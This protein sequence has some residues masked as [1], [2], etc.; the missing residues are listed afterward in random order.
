MER[1]SPT[2]TYLSNAEVG[3]LDALYHDYQAN[4][5]SVDET[6][7]RFFEGFEFARSKY[8]QNGKTATAVAAAAGV[9]EE[10]LGR[11]H[12]VQELINAYR[13]RGHLFAKINPILP[14]KKY[15]PPISLEL[16]GLSESDL[17][18]EFHAGNLLGIGTAK[19]RDIVAFLE[20]TYC[21]TIGAEYRYIRI[22][23]M[24]EWL[25]HKMEAKRNLPTFAPAEKQHILEML[26]K[27]TFFENFIHRKFPGQKRFS[28]EGGESIIPALDSLIMQG[29]E[30][31]VKEFVIGMAHRGRLNILTN[32]L[33]KEPDN[34]FGEFKDKGVSDSIFDGDVKYH[35]GYSSDPV[36]A[37]GKTVHLSLAPNP[38][39]LEAVAPVVAGVTRAKMEM[40][41]GNDSDAICPIIIHGDASVAGQGIVYELIQMSRL[42][43]YQTGGTVHFVINNQIGFTTPEDD[44]R[45]STYCTDVAK[46]TASPVFHVNG[47]D[48]EAVAYVSRLAMEFRQVFKRDVFVDIICYRKYGHN[49]GD[50]PRF[51]QPVMYA[52]IAKHPS[53]YEIYRK[54]L[55][56]AATMTQAQVDAMEKAIDDYLNDELDQSDANEYK[57]GAAL[58]RSWDG[59]RFYD[60]ENVEA[61]PATGVERDMLLEIV[62]RIS[63]APEGFPVH[64]N[65]ERLLQ[66][67]REMVKA[68]AIDWGLGE[69]LAFGTL[70][71]EG[72]PVRITGQDVERGTFSHRH[73]VIINQNDNSKHTPLNHLRPGQAPLSIYNS[74]LSEYAVLGFEH[75]YSTARPNGL[76]IWEAQFGD[77][78]N[79]AQIIID[80]F[81]ASGTTKWQR[82]SGVTLLL[83]HGYEGQGPEHSSA[84]IERFLELCA[85]NN[86]YV[87]NITTPA[88]LF[89]ALRRQRIGAF[90]RPLVVFTPKSLL[91]AKECVSP[92]EAFIPG[93]QFQ[94]VLDD[95]N[96]ALKPASV[97]RVV[98]TSGKLFYDLVQARDKHKKLDTAIVRLEQYYPVPKAQLDALVREKYAKAKEIIWA[99]EEPLNMGGWMFILRQLRDYNPEGVGRKDSP[100]PATGSKSQHTSQQ[101]Y[102]VRKS[103]N[104]PPDAKVF[105]K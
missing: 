96:A 49:E 5:D 14:R 78:V 51:T 8:S 15:D 41:Y 79:G 102:I 105:D 97:K 34:V 39:H 45:S 65:I 84:R 94:E 68:N 98:I 55:L 71:L 35:M 53:P 95:P 92:L 90:R 70:L 81:I 11:E 33:R 64:R 88:N 3:F 77:F 19:L 59:F 83:P 38:S 13:T 43:A 23:K 9:S 100:S 1:T 25:E 85:S 86:M 93:T 62:D 76:T 56:D 36:L 67:R 72:T 47:D 7:R 20:T 12:A 52:N 61:N 30:L 104:L 46:V 22:P 26:G 63:Q 103:L 29:S 73:A 4:P 44:A 87:C 54:Q 80:Q 28:L 16:F 21:R 24:L 74:L 10:R 101:E 57:L 82:M 60:T 48:P 58:T 2:A 75:G 66:Q 69:H 18:T 50:E 40:L 37:N 42:P 89:H 6:W 27:A 32:I 17:D 31:G 99:Q 91:R